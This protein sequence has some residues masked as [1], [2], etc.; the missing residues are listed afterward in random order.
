MS[1]LIRDPL[2]GQLLYPEEFKDVL[3]L[4]DYMTRVKHTP[5]KKHFYQHALEAFHWQRSQISKRDK[6]K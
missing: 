5:A 6:S 3:F 2:E 1:K 4:S